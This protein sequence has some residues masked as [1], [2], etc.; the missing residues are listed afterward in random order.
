MH[1]EQTSML[2]YTPFQRNGTGR[3]HAGIRIESRLPVI[4]ELDYTIG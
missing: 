3:V 4:T 1:P 2:A